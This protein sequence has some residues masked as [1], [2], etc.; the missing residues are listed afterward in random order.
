MGKVHHKCTGQD[1]DIN[2]R[3]FVLYMYL[4]DE[5]IHIC[6]FVLYMYLQDEDINISI[7]EYIP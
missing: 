4:Q 5:D 2:I 1:E 7:Y 3:M 6:M